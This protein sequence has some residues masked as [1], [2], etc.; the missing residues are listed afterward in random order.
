MS[1]VVVVFSEITCISSGSNARSNLPSST[2]VIAVLSEYS[3]KNGAVGLACDAETVLV[4]V[5]V[6]VEAEAAKNMRNN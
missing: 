6:E 5:E 2:G 1:D 4:E 3:S